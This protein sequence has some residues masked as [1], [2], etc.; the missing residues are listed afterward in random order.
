MSVQLAAK[1]EP[2]VYITGKPSV[3]YFSSV[4]FRHSPFMKQTYEVPF[5]NQPVRTGFTSFCT[6]PVNGDIISDITL[7]TILPVGSVAYYDGVG[8]RLI[9]EARLT[10][11]A[12]VISTLTGA[13]IDLQNNVNVP[14]ENQAA[15]TGLVGVADTTIS[16]KYLLT[17]L[18]F[19]IANLPICCLGRHDVILEIDFGTVLSSTQTTSNTV[20]SSF[21]V[22]YATVGQSELKWFTSSRQLYVY[23][24]MQYLS[25][26]TVNQG[27]NYIS[28]DGVITGSVKELYVTVQDPSQTTTYTYSTALTS[29]GLTFCGQDL[30]T[31]DSA[32]WSLIQPF[33]TKIITPTRNLYMYS[34]KG[35]VNFSRIAD[36]QLRLTSSSGP[37]NL[38]VYAKTL[39]V[40]AAENGLGSFVFV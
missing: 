6:L 10:V 16:Q 18:D 29:I 13:Y 5:D 26:L 24:S 33:E 8:T 35:P 23:E 2:D 9:N 3:T 34:F 40:F 31:Y 32:Y 20:V 27:D 4:Y 21:L 7:K 30:I 12:Q 38:V 22:E 15:L 19:G 14:Y 25:S 11:G 37:L 17:K 1:G 36:V 28:L 39:N